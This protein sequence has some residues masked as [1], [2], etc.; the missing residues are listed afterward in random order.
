MQTTIQ[1]NNKL[2]VGNLAFETTTP[3]LQDLFGQA[4]TVTDS[5]VMTDAMNG[6]SRGFGFVTM[7]SADEA[8]EAI[9]RFSGSELQGR[10]LTVNEARPRES[11]GGSGGRQFAGREHREPRRF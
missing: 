4:G 3:D 8:Q 7:S 2:Y 6:K 1:M 5:I 11:R 9:R 10:A